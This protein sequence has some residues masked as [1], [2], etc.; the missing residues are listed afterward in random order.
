[1]GKG[2]KP[3]PNNLKKFYKNFDTINWGKNTK[4]TKG[5]KK[6]SNALSN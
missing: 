5:K 2:S 3:R 4:P 6:T 1:M